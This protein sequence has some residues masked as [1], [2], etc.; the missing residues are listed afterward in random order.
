VPS[1][2]PTSAPTAQVIGSSEAPVALRTEVPTAEIIEEPNPNVQGRS[3]LSPEGIVGISLG[4]GLVI[5]AALAFQR[6][7]RRQEMM[8]ANAVPLDSMLSSDPGDSLP[9]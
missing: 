2:A 9:M 4:S 5:L 8:A 1:P 6:R 7:R 3:G